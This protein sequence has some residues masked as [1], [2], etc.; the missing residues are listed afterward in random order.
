[1]GRPRV[2]LTRRHGYRATL[3]GACL[4][5]SSCAPAP[6]ASAPQSAVVGAPAAA[7]DGGEIF[8]FPE[9][10][11]SP[12]EL[13]AVPA[14]LQPFLAQCRDGDAALARVAER[15][16]RRQAEGSPALDVSELSF[17]LRAEGSPYVWPRAWT[18]E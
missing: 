15:F 13:G 14:A 9:A 1:M 16:A 5:L 12:L 10:T 2:T 11:V 6:H 17:T 18:L 4:A 7:S 8:A 3:T